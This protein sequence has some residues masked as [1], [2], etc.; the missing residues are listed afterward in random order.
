MANRLDVTSIGDGSPTLK[1]EHMTKLNKAEV[2]FMYDHA[3]EQTRRVMIESL[4]DRMETLEK[5]DVPNAEV[6]T[7]LDRIG[8]TD[9]PKPELFQ[10]FDIG[11]EPLWLVAPRQDLELLF[12]NIGRVFQLET[13]Y[14]DG[15]LLRVKFV[16]GNGYLKTLV[17]EAHRTEGPSADTKS[18]S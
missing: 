17:A 3:D 9:E 16:P 18:E 12:T 13:L 15:D 5:E 4:V 7:F 2:L 1:D 14:E 10:V 8:W 6:K 11:T